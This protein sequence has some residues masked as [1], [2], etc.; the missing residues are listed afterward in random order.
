MRE[1]IGDYQF[2]YVQ[3][4]VTPG[5]VRVYIEEQP[6]Y[7]GQSEDAHATHRRTTDVPDAPPYIC[8][9]EESKPSTLDE[10]RTRAREWIDY[11]DRYIETGETG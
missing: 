11:T 10:A 3:D 2:R 7:Q 4:V 5:K 6:S 9:K 8:F 1:R